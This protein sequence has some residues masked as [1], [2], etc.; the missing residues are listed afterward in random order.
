MDGK[1]MY[2]ALNYGT[3]EVDYRGLFHHGKTLSKF[4]ETISLAIFEQE[5]QFPL[6]SKVARCDRNAFWRFVVKVRLCRRAGGS[7]CQIVNPK[8]NP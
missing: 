5:E 7:M 3:L 4:R 8:S 6:M 1:Q 2:P